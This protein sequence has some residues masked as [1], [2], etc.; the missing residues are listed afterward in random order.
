MLVDGQGRD[1][2]RGENGRTAAEEGCWMHPGGRRR[3][4]RGEVALGE[5]GGGGSWVWGLEGVFGSRVSLAWRPAA[6]LA[7]GYIS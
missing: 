2:V 4:R 7:D 5:G 3:R 1:L 6:N